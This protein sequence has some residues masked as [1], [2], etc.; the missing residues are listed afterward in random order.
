MQAKTGR[1]LLHKPEIQKIISIV[2]NFLKKR[3]RICYGGTAINNILPEKY[4]FYNREIELPD[5]D[6]FS[7]EPLEDAKRLADIY[8]NEGFI[9]VEAKSG[10]HAGTFKVFVNFIPIADITYMPEKLYKTILKHALKRD[11]IYYSPPDF[12]RMLMYLELSRPKGN[13]D[14]WEKVLKRLQ[15]LNKVYPL[16]SRKCNEIEIQRMFDDPGTLKEKNLFY[17]VRDVLIKEGVVFFGGYAN[18]M[19]LRYHKAFKKYPHILTPDFDVL[20]MDPKETASNIKNTLRNKGF[21]NIRVDK[22]KAVGEIISESYSVRWGSER[23]VTIYKPL[24]CHSYNVR[25]IKHHKIYIATIDTMLSFYLAFLY[26][27][28]PKF[29]DPERLKC[30]SEYLFKVQRENRLEQKGILRRFSINCYG[31]QHT[32]ADIRLEKTEKYKELKNKK[33]T[34]AYEWY[35]LRYSPSEKKTTK[36]K[37][38]KRKRRRLKKTRRRRRKRSRRISQLFNI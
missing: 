9:E 12:L 26:A 7:P 30:M 25:H 31:T 15:L 32:L 23:L 11:N 20:S 33:Q 28:R 13:T 4:Q 5:Y 22:K 6:F 2:E 1:H 35:F 18:R 34:K 16:Q 36:K 10:I 24:G 21:K 3:K 37:T 27:N 17:I 29:Y 14:R 8:F 38:K 19:Y